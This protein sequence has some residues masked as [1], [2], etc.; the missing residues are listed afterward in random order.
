MK[1]YRVYTARLHYHEFN[2]LVGEMQAYTV[3]QVKEKMRQQKQNEDDK[4]FNMNPFYFVIVDET[5]GA[6]IIEHNKHLQFV[7]QK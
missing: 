6:Q 2:K 1:T 7:K 4:L 5:D 3:E